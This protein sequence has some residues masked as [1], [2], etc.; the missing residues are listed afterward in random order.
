[1]CLVLTW[2]FI[3]F[4]SLMV[5][6]LVRHSKCLIIRGQI[7]LY[8]RFQC[9]HSLNLITMLK[10]MIFFLFLQISVYLAAADPQGCCV[11]WTHSFTLIEIGGSLSQGSTSPDMNDVSFFFFIFILVSLLKGLI[12][13]VTVVKLYGYYVRYTYRIYSADRHWRLRL[14][15][16]FRLYLQYS[17][18]LMDET[19]LIYGM[20]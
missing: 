16:T 19:S 5:I 12:V 1:M 14:N 18:N 20:G 2:Y 7:T 17:W 4:L 6:C 3:Y 8:N 13:F 9:L 11:A 10:A 15:M